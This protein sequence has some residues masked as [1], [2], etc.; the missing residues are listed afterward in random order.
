MKIVARLILLTPLMLLV[1]AGFAGSEDGLTAESR[2]VPAWATSP[3]RKTLLAALKPPKRPG[4]PVIAVIGLNEGTETTDYLVPF[5]VLKRADVADVLALSTRS[6]PIT[7]M[8]ALNIMP[9]ATVAEFEHEYPEGA[10]YV[11]VP[12]MFPADDPETTGWISAQAAKG[13]IIVG[14]CTGARV[15]GQAG[16][17]VE[18]R[19]TSHWYDLATVREENPTMIYVPNRRYVFD[20]GVASSTGVSA[21]IPVSLTLIEAIA[22]YQQA[23]KVA[24]ELG[25]DNWDDQHQSD[26]FT[27]RSDFL[28]TAALNT[29]AFWRHETLRIDI[30]P[31]VDEIALGLTADAWSRT[32]Q[33][34]VLIAADEEVVTTKGGIRVV[35]DKKQEYEA[36]DASL[37]AL[38]ASFPARALDTSLQQIGER[39]GRPT[40][41]F[42]ATQLE[43]S[44]GLPR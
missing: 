19:A 8:P 25:V 32:Y 5:G 3:D 20:R 21:S 37:P 41:K 28:I 35:P 7:L 18:R 13:A 17:L 43:Y 1:P 16:L 27:A 40:R 24:L 31:G 42:V 14:I 12:A 9:D 34:K 33:S 29:L 11:I 36:S 22:G 6:G 39:Y 26:E 44:A 23:A 30:E 2:D 15:L 38:A 10:D 4:R